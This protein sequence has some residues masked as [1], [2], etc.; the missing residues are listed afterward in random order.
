MA[1]HEKANIKKQAEVDRKYRV[2]QK[3][4]QPLFEQVHAWEQDTFSMTE[5]PFQ[6]RVD[7]NATLLA[8]ANSDTQQGN[9]L[10]HLQQ[11]YGNRYVQRLIEAI[12]V[13][14]KLMVNAPNDIYEQEADRVAGVVTRAIGSQ[15]QRQPEEEE[16][17]LQAKSI[18]QRAN[19]ELVPQV[20]SEME[21]MINAA[22]GSGEPLHDNIRE[23]MEQ[24][25][26]ANFGGVRVHRDSDADALSQSLQAR[27]FTT[28]QDIF[29]RSGEYNQLTSTGQQ[30]IAHELTH[31]VQQ[32]GKDEPVRTADQADYLTENETVA[33]LAPAKQSPPVPTSKPWKKQPP[34]VPASKPWKREGKAPPVPTDKPWKQKRQKPEQVTTEAEEEL[35]PTKEEE[36]EPVPTEKDEEEALIN[37][38][39]KL[40]GELISAE[41]FKKKTRLTLWWL[42]RKGK[43]AEFFA[44]VVNQLKGYE[45]KKGA[46]LA[47]KVEYLW[48]LVKS[49]SSW[50]SS[51]GKESSRA[52]HVEALATQ[53]ATEIDL[54]YINEVGAWRQEINGLKEPLNKL[55]YLQELLYVLRMRDAPGY[56]SE[57][58][59][60]TLK[61]QLAKLPPEI[62]D[63]IDRLLMEKS[64]TKGWFTK[65]GEKET[66]EEHPSGKL[67]VLDIVTYKFGISE[68]ET[69]GKFEQVE[70]EEFTGFFKAKK[71]VG[72]HV[73]GMGIPEKMPGFHRRTMAMYE[74]DKVLGANVI[75]PAFLAKHGGKIGTVL[76]KVENKKA[77]GEEAT[78][79]EKNQPQ[80]QKSLSNLF[81]LDIIAGQVD[82]HGGNYIFEVEGGVIKGVKGI[83]LDLAFG[84]EFTGAEVEKLNQ[85]LADVLK[86]KEKSASN[87]EYQNY[88][89][90]K[91][92]I[93]NAIY[94]KLPVEL[95]EIDQEF[96]KHIVEM[97]ESGEQ[98]IQ[99]ALAGLLPEAEINATI[100]RLKSLAKILK[101]MIGKD[102]G[103]VIAK[104]EE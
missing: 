4:S 25:F 83:D 16:E 64:E 12:A 79:E 58:E 28:G 7:K 102:T 95:E 26:G 46:P 84:E 92:D 17:E 43:S 50:L 2:S 22:K 82:R 97:A 40:I 44:D 86:G 81:L 47:D 19:T 68:T 39:P 8:T 32:T 88:R 13:Q 56:E 1:E 3:E 48:K 9:L 33:S 23:P 18:L 100:D 90:A 21:G 6:P 65:E 11:T 41:E 89:N 24:A 73:M 75:A 15:V 14:P 87:A 94:G 67:N 38:S 60:S 62:D 51:D 93:E 52:K 103:P 42:G 29:F 101:Q 5:T 36:K 66:S 35:I 55:K 57:I 10:I 31:V 96:A 72:K 45:G 77:T 74:L 85:K 99:N 71:N 76:A 54:Q 98:L 59:K 63:E 80:V 49:V 104:S 91:A 69:K 30:L 53:L 37:E 70:G 27:A 20:N 61:G 78:S 34:P